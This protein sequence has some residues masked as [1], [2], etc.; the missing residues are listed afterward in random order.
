V[1]PT[2]FQKLCLGNRR[3]TETHFLWN[4]FQA[5]PKG[6][7]DDVMNQKKGVNTIP[8]KKKETKVSN[9]SARWRHSQIKKLTSFLEIFQIF[10]EICNMFQ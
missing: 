4:P 5:L 1:D 2:L 10:D 6:A 3:S 9:S 7:F 8:Y